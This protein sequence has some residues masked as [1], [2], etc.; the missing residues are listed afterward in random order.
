MNI[1]SN[2]MGWLQGLQAQNQPQVQQS[3]SNSHIEKNAEL[4]S[5]QTA[6]K[7]DSSAT[8]GQNTDSVQFSQLAQKLSESNRINLDAQITPEERQAL[9]ALNEPQTYKPSLMQVARKI[10]GFDEA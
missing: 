5:E 1:T 10:F 2:L 8:A 4:A 7:V 6:K 3:T 9:F